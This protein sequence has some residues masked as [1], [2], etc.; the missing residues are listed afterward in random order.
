MPLQNYSNSFKVGLLQGRDEG[1]NKSNH[2]GANKDTLNEH[3]GQ[4][5]PPD[6][7]A[8]AK[9]RRRSF[10]LGKARRCHPRKSRRHR[11]V[12]WGTP[13]GAHTRV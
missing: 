10:R 11:P 4:R 2:H 6:A 8:L 7:I 9:H 3:Q 1:I 12:A 5:R 13:I